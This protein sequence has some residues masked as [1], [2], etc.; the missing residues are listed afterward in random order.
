MEVLTTPVF[1]AASRSLHGRAVALTPRAFHAAIENL[2]GSTLLVTISGGFVVGFVNVA[3]IN[4][5]TGSGVQRSRDPVD[6]PAQ[7][8]VRNILS[9]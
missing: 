1:G 2:A 7:R 6:I 3:L 4:A 9:G 5:Y 8:A